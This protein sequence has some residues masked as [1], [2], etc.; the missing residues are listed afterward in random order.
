MRAA[1]TTALPTSAPSWGQQFAREIVA[2]APD[3]LEHGQE[4]V[5][6]PAGPPPATP[7]PLRRRAQAPDRGLAMPARDPTVLVQQ[8]AAFP[9]ARPLIPLTHHL[10]ILVAPSF[11]HGASFPVAVVTPVLR[12]PL[13][14]R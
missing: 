2:G 10:G 5:A 12:H 3:L 14:F 4:L 9:P 7:A 6:I 11:R 8:G 13:S 1:S